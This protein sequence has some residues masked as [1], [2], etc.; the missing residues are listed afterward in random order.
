[1]NS[2]I[3]DTNTNLN[4]D[5]SVRKN[6]SGNMSGTAKLV[7]C[8]MFTALT[9]ICS[10]IQIELPFTPV[11]VNL[12]TLAVMLAGCILGPVYGTVSQIVY[13]LLGAIGAPVFSGG[14]GGFGIIAGPTG[15]YIVGYMLC[16]A[17]CGMI[18]QSGSSSAKPN[19]IK[20]IAAMVLG[21]LLC[22]TAGTLWFMYITDNGLV[23][24]LLMCVVPYLPG[25]AL[26]MAAAAVLVRRLP[27]S[28]MQ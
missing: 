13:V 17:T 21:T 24:S 14:A 7:I 11:P 10:W 9:A 1:M 6:R 20:L 4:A 16:A 3:T 8:A 12:A 5:A 22:Y 18:M 28:L 26:K 19:I 2:N 25:D 27:R 15:G 23:P